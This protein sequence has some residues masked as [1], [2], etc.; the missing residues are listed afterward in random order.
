MPH[1]GL[2]GISDSKTLRASTYFLCNLSA[3]CFP[4]PCASPL[5]TEPTTESKAMT[6][7]EHFLGN[8]FRRARWP[9]YTTYL[10]FW[11]RVSISGVA[12]MTLPR[13]TAVACS[14]MGSSARRTS[15][16]SGQERDFS[17]T[18]PLCANTPPRTSDSLP[19]LLDN[20]GEKKNPVSTAKVVIRRRGPCDLAR[21][22]STTRT[23][24]V[25]DTRH[26][27]HLRNTFIGEHSTPDSEFDFT[28]CMKIVSVNNTL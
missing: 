16:N 4:V 12:A 13:V 9:C 5:P 17:H 21:Q 7:K 3:I 27:Q 6:L 24:R 11:C 26:R 8:S 19:V 1:R 2:T 18:H 20:I 15:S 10:I 22:T 23:L 14:T 25:N 28:Y